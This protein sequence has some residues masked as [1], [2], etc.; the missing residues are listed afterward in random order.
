MI[1]IMKNDNKA[2]SLETMFENH[3][4]RS[5][6]IL[7]KKYREFISLESV[8]S[9]ILSI[10]YLAI[11]CQMIEKR[12]LIYQI[13]SLYLLMI[14][15]YIGIIG[16]LFAGLA[17]MASIMTPKALKRIDNEGKILQ[18]SS[19]LFSFYFCGALVL[20]S[21]GLAALFFI[22]TQFELLEIYVLPNKLFLLFAEFGLYFL[23]FALIYTVSLIGS[24]IKLYF[25]NIYME[26]K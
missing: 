10:G 5:F 23:V 16:F 22:F 8:C 15:P 20:I 11:E 3:S 12:E 19:I 25:L 1:Q 2:M 9:F 7:T 4:F 17:L 18:F 24:C 21:I 13:Y 26:Q 14:P 6:F